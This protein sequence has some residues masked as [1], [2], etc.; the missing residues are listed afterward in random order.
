MFYNENIISYY[1]ILKFCCEGK[2][3]FVK[4]LIIYFLGSEQHTLRNIWMFDITL[5]HSMERQF[6][7]GC[8][9]PNGF[10]NEIMSTGC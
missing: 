7:M 8:P 6:I 4:F 2:Y 9:C 3:F 1:M 5:M 10:W